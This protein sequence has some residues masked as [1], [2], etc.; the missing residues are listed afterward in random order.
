[1]RRR[2][3]TAALLAALVALAPAQSPQSPQEAQYVRWLEERSMLF[4]AGEQ[5]KLI[6]GRGVQWRHPYG[7]P[8]PLEVVR[9]AS[10]WLLDYPGALVFV[11]H[12]RAFLERVATRIVELDRG[13]LTSWPGDYAT[14][15]RKKEEWLAN[16]AIGQEK[17][18]KRLAEEEAWL[19]QGIKARRTRNEGREL[20]PGHHRGPQP[21][22]TGGLSH[23]QRTNARVSRAGGAIE[24]EIDGGHPANRPWA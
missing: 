21:A 9:K 18:D 22:T 1:M 11:T 20:R 13:R 12:D 14:F 16:E 4:Q 3:L 5:A 24:A 23:G 17:F 6:S 8:R 10:V 7:E 15:V 19:R 2:T